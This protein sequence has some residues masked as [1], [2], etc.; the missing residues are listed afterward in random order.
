[1]RLAHFRPGKNQS[2]ERLEIDLGLAR[3]PDLGNDRD[4]E[5]ERLS[6]ESA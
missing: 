5:T 4:R 1:V 3:Q 2:L 6:D